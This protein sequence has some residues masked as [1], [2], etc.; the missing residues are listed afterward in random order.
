MP[1]CI[2]QISVVIY[3][4]FRGADLPEIKLNFLDQN[5]NTLGSSNTLSSLN[6]T[7]TMVAE[8]A[9]IP[10]QTRKI[11][12]ELKGTRNAGTDND[13]YFDDLF[14]R[15]G[16]ENEDCDSTFTSIGPSPVWAPVLQVVPNPFTHTATIAIPGLGDLQGKISIVNALGE[17]VDCA[18]RF[19][20][21]KIILSRGSLSAG[22]YF[23]RVRSENR[24]IGRGKFV[25][26]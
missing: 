16:M 19:E 13:S 7:W 21:D 1:R 9:S 24:L 23:F 11:Q 15:V 4:T 3:P 10:P 25:V 5:S 20:S 22:T 2:Q 26:D 6:D 18:A 14:L 17:K 12:V 8:W